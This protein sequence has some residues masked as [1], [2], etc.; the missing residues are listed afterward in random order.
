MPSLSAFCYALGYGAGLLAFIAMA[1][2][3]GMA[4]EGVMLLAGAGL[5]GGLIGAHLAQMLAGGLQEWGGKSILGAIAGG[6]LSVAFVKRRIGLLR[7]TGDLFAVALCAGEAFG[8]WGCYFG[9]CCYG[10]AT[11]LPWAVWQHGAW[12][13]PTQIYA[14]LAAVLILGALWRYER[15]RP[16]ENGLFFLQGLLYCGARFGIEFLRADHAVYAGLSAAQWACA[17]G[18]CYFGARWWKLTRPAARIPALV[19]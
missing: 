14:S 11:T 17:A 4:T 18:A 19:S 9:G 3:R 13:H 7:P 5:I 12:R 15:T 8:R 1:R 6:W 16:P 2:R 10:K